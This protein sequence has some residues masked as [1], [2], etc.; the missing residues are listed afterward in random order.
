MNVAEVKL[1]FELAIQDLQGKDVDRLRYKIRG[2]REVRELWMMRSD[3]HELIAKQ[4]SQ[5]VAAKAI[6][7]LL[8]CFEGWIPAQQLI[9]I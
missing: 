5:G 3:V 2:M 4:Q 7:Q 1:K 8:P 9:K 6:N